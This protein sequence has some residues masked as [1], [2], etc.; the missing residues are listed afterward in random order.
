MMEHASAEAHTHSAELWLK[1]AGR[2]IGMRPVP[3]PSDP[4]LLRRWN[5]RSAELDDI[6]FN[7]VDGLRVLFTLHGPTDTEDGPSAQPTCSQCRDA[8]G[9]NVAFPCRTYRQVYKLTVGAEEYGAAAN[10]PAQE[11]EPES[12]TT[13][14]RLIEVHR[15]EFGDLVFSDGTRWEADR[16]PD[17]EHLDMEMERLRAVDGLMR[18]EAF[19]RFAGRR[20]GVARSL[21]GAEYEELPDRKKSVVDGAMVKANNIIMDESWGTDR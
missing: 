15:D 5:D 2:D 9:R 14:D 4:D 12:E 7:A 13:E 21:F 1:Q 3:Y 8:T 11:G 6:R 18:D 10:V 16:F 19:D 17:R 20:D